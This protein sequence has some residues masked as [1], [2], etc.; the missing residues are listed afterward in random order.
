[1]CTVSFSTA[2]SSY[3]KFFYN[4]STWFSERQGFHLKED[5]EA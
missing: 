4:V 2:V 1:M 5:P 3:A